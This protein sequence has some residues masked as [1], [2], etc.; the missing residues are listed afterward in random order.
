MMIS[1]ASIWISCFRNDFAQLVGEEF[2]KYFDLKGLSLDQ[3][4]RA[5]LRHITLAGETQERE[6]VLAHFSHRYME[7]NP[8][9]YNSEGRYRARLVSPI[10]PA[11]TQEVHIRIAQ[12][13]FE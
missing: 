9:T 12:G 4:V 11:D 10:L 2:L 8:N 13:Y 1:I 7:C 6:R 5:F 3:A